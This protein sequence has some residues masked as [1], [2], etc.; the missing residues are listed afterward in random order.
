[1]RPVHYQGDVIGR[2]AAPVIAIPVAAKAGLKPEQA[3]AS[4]PMSRQE[5]TELS[6]KS[7]QPSGKRKARDNA[8]AFRSSD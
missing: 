4:E 1:V 3:S 7:K 8:R 5:K 2:G 6:G